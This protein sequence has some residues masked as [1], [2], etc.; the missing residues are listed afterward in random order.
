M[1]SR[2]GTVCTS[3]YSHAF[4][5]NFSPKASPGVGLWALCSRL[6]LCSLGSP[7]GSACAMERI[8]RLP[9]HLSSKQAGA[10]G[11]TSRG[12]VSVPVPQ[13]DGFAREQNV[14]YLTGSTSNKW[15]HVFLFP[16]GLYSVWF[17]VRSTIV[18]QNISKHIK[19]IFINWNW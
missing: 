7:R 14:F 18:D 5:L 13:Q 4:E 19:L 12:L 2:L 17:S 6:G 15:R 16:H 10:Q 1:S 8:A 11:P 9:D 3:I